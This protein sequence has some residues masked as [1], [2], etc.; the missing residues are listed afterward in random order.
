MQLQ[1]YV[2]SLFILSQSQTQRKKTRTEKSFKN[3][4]K[5]C[6]CTASL[7][8]CLFDQWLKHL[9]HRAFKTSSLTNLLHWCFNTTNTAE[10]FSLPQ[11]KKQKDKQ[12]K[13]KLTHILR[14]QPAYHLSFLLQIAAHWHCTHMAWHFLLLRKCVTYF[15]LGR[16]HCTTVFFVCWKWHILNCHN[17]W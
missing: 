6:I 12:A 8:T 3:F 2:P 11:K 5:S 15:A 13:N 1:M 7:L 17:A 16:N 9:S 4:K 10:G 14:S